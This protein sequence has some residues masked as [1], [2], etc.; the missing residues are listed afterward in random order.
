MGEKEPYATQEERNKL[1]IHYDNVT[2]LEVA[3]GASSHI[4]STDRVTIESIVFEP[5]SHYPPHCHE[6]EQIMLLR[7]GAGDELVDGKLYHLEKGD[8]IIIPS[9]I[10]HGLHVS[11]KGCRFIVVSSP[12]RYDLMARL[13]ASKN[14]SGLK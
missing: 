9:N 2:P 12:P 13:E 3:P 1:V 4:I 8:V 11:D 10:E 14:E 6:A 5:N 7:D